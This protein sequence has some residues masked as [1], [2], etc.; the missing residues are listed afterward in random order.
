ME[1]T[2]TT[3]ATETTPETTDTDHGP[4]APGDELAELCELL[5][6]FPPLVAQL[7]ETLR[8][9]RWLITMHRKVKDSPPDDLIAESTMHEFPVDEI[10]GTMQSQCR[11]ILADE[12]QRIRLWDGMASQ[13]SRWR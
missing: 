5:R 3:P 8:C 1:T 13:K 11:A 2:E 10:V 7:T 6:A 4:R 12:A 9:G